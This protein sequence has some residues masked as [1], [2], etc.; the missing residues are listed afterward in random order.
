MRGKG[1]RSGVGKRGKGPRSGVGKRGERSPESLGRRRFVDVWCAISGDA[2]LL[3]VGFQL[4]DGWDAVDLVGLDI[5]ELL[6]RREDELDQVGDFDVRR[7]RN[8]KREQLLDD[9]AGHPGAL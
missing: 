8:T 4:L 7:V 6:L 5:H 3:E 9:V 1:P 2:R